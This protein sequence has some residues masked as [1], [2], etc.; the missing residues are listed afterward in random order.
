V[1]D[2]ATAPATHT[3]SSAKG[4]VWGALTAL[5]FST[6][7]VVGKDLLGALGPASLLFWRFS[8]ATGVLWLIL[9]AWRARGGPDPRS[10]PAVRLI[11]LGA[12]LG[13]VVHLGLLSLRYLD[14]SVYIVVVY[15]YPAFVVLGS[16]ALGRPLDRITVFSLAVITGGV[17]LTVPELF[18][19]VGSISTAGVLLAVS[20][21]VGYAAYM[22]LSDRV[23]PTGVDGMVV[24]SWT[25]L[26]AA[27]YFVPFVVAGGLVV[28]DTSAIRLEVMLF[29][30]IPTV[31]ATTCFFR[32]LRHIVPG[33]LA[34]IMTTEVALTIL[35]SATFLHEHVSGLEA[36]GAGVVIAG[37]ALA[38]RTDPV[39]EDKV[40][41]GV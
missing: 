41:V 23:V 37:V 28:P 40:P 31:M 35:W 36:L 4:A 16:A 5:S 8:L 13:A 25:N 27:I 7:S 12:M 2:T 9:A 18:T 24:A 34:M 17:V 15:L 21:G 6:S 10:V 20:Q 14:V 38:Q 22:L 33:L 29:A 26:G 32:A 1:H 11:A 30:L 19:G 39:A 3:R